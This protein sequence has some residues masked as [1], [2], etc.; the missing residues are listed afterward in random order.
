MPF[1]SYATPADV[2]RVHRI[3]LSG[4]E[5]ISPL[6]H[7]V[8][9]GLRRD[10][11]LSQ[12]YFARFGSESAVSES[13]IFPVLKEV[14]TAYTDDLRLWIREPLVYDADLSGTPDY[15]VSRVSPLG[16]DVQD[17]PYLIIMEAKRDDPARGWGQCLAAMLAAQKLNE[18]AGAAIYGVTTNGRT[19]E[20]GKLSDGTFTI[21]PRPFTLIDLD[22]IC[23]ALHYVFEQCRQQVVSQPQPA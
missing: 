14:W 10:V 21:D 22:G 13:L 8:S 16:V 7:P 4:G 3:A 19:W 9:D 17:R 6:P 20:F 18:S 12:K 2:A 23:A 1:T 11:A 15:F 5:F